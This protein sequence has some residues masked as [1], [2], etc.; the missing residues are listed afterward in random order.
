MSEHREPP[1]VAVV[2][3]LNIDLVAYTRRVPN[4][5]ETVIGERF[6]MGFGGKGANQAVMA[7]RLGASVAMVG[8][9]GDDVYARM[10]LDN[11]A[12]QGVDAATVA[13]VAGSSGV[14]PIWVET[15]G[16]NRI[17][18]VP[19]ANDLVDPDAAA[20]AIGALDRLDVVLGQ[21]EIPQ[22]ATLAAFRVAR[23]RGA[24]TILNPAPAASL[25]PDLIEASH[26]LI[27][28]ET[29]FAILAGLDRF[30]PDDDAA[31]TAYA[32]RVSP[33]LVLTL[34]ARG[35][36]IVSADGQ[37][38]RIPATAVEAVDTTG[39][40]DAFVGAFAVGLAGGL[41]ERAAVRLGI[42]CASDSVTRHGT[43]SSFA[44]REVA[45]AMLEEIR[46]EA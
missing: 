26:W 46:G 5:G 28:N 17:I 25:D 43:Q 7:A 18:V 35:A 32:R 8:A 11:L 33:R 30:D 21:L 12:R 42:A 45:C 1:A 22:R 40:G 6:Q 2:G 9:L 34:G 19:G 16:T 20:T 14:A 38:E 29:E 4:A 31:I 13:R 39:A 10:T 15:G 27:P 36:A 24:V 41:N 3:S 44:S 23:E 37:V